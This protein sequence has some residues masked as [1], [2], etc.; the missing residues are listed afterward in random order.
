M[1]KTGLTLFELLISMLLISAMLGAIWMIFRTGLITF[2]GTSDRQNIS[3]QASVAFTTMTNELRQ[4][5]SV[6][7]ATGTA[8]RFYADVNSDGVNEDIQYI[9]NGTAGAP[10]NRV[11]TAATTQTMALVRSV[12][13][14]LPSATNPLF[15]YY[16][17]NNSDL[18]L[19]PTVANVQL[20]LIELYTYNDLSGT[21]R[22]HLRTKVG[23]R[24]I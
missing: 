21:E 4:A 10:L 12:N 14:P 8:V 2:Y 18:G 13:N 6:I 15:H 23:L 19:T 22:F 3:D 16:G 11:L 17:A 24:C 1:T 9:W 5:S 7:S 20:V